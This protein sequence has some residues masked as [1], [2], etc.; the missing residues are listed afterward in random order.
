[1]NAISVDYRPSRILQNVLALGMAQGFTWSASFVTILLLPAHL[2]STD[3]GRYYL[4]TMLAAFLLLVADL[5]I[6]TYLVKETSRSDDNTAASLSWN[7]AALGLL[8]GLGATL[9]GAVLC[10]FIIRDSS[11]RFIIYLV[12]L[13]LPTQ[14]IAG[15]LLA[16]LRGAEDMVPIAL[17][18]SISRAISLGIVVA[19]V[20]TGQGVVSIC[21]AAVL[22]SVIY[23]GIAG[24]AFKSR[25]GVMRTIRPKLFKLILA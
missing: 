15:R 24:I 5:G 23:F 21:L 10:H 3:L 6:G 13:S 14:A 8:M 9:I 4:A 16:S 17:A 2:G 12:L 20:L 22:G 7:G 19:L 18:E 25:F 11:T 1:M